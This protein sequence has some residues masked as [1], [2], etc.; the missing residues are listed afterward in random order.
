MANHFLDVER[1]Q[2]FLVSRSV[3]DWL[4]EEDLLAIFVVDALDEI[5]REP[6]SAKYRQ[7]R[8]GAPRRNAVRATPP[9]STVERLAG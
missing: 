8:R 6:S 4:E 5:D 9:S 7:T 3:T 1:D 2:L